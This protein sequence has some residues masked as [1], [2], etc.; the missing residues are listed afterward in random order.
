MGGGKREAGFLER[1]HA[2]AP[3]VGRLVLIL[4]QRIV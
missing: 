2:I 3:I 1:D 4:S